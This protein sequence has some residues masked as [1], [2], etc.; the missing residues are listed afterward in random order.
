MKHRH[1]IL[2]AWLGLQA[3]PGTAAEPATAAAAAALSELPPNDVV[4]RVLIANPTVQAAGGQIRV[5]EANRDRL[6]AGSYEWNVRLGR[7]Q[8]KIYPAGAAEQRFNEWDAALERPLRLPGKAAIDADL[9]AAGVAL[10]QTANGDALHETGRLLLHA[11]FVWLRETATARQ[12]QAQVDLLEKQT[13]AIRRRQQL[14]DAARLDTVLAEG[15]LAQARAQLTQAQLQA[16]SAEETL[17]LR[18]PGLPLQQPANITEP[19]VLEGSRDAWVERVLNASHELK[20]AYGLTQQARLAAERARRNRIPDPTVGINV[21]RERGGEEHI[22][23]AYISIP[24]P[25][26]AR[27]ADSNAA[28]AALDVA[29][30]QE[31]AARQKVSAEAAILY[32]STLAARQSWLA[33]KES[34]E[35]MEHAAQMSGRAYQLGERSLS[36][37]LTA[38]R[39][40]NEAQLT[41]RQMRFEALEQRYRLLLDA[42]EIWDFDEADD[43]APGAPTPPAQALG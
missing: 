34:A 1:M 32:Q 12:W 20:L 16:Q 40:A 36:D 25:G 30:R 41:E 6:E 42:H 17:R 3:L 39:L 2:L 43:A 8:R 31:E 23:G 22:I 29:S 33:V 4:R 24:L 11:W 10:A 38:R 35:R 21:G 15:A 19:A 37:L 27:R 26:Q 9:G 5:E 14:G 13:H 18:F 28:Q 7:Q